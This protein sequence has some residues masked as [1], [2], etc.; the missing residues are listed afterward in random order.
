MHCRATS[1]PGH[2]NTAGLLPV[3]DIAA[4]QGCF[5]YWILQQLWAACNTGYYSTAGLLTVLDMFAQG[6]G[7]EERQ[8]EQ[9]Q[10]ERRG[11]VG[12]CSETLMCISVL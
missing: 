12:S 4:L 2:F 11:E 6:E 8:Q 3:L 7:R 5:E 10:E 9:E 1:S